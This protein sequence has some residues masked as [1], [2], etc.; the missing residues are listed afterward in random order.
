MNYALTLVALA[1]LFF[2]IRSSMIWFELLS[3]AEDAPP[4]KL[5]QARLHAAVSWIAFVFPVLII[6]Q[7]QSVLK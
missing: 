3:T 2:A 7:S 4:G 1:N 5:A 6:W